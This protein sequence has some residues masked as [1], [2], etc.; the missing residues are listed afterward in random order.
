MI[1]LSLPYPPSLWK[2]YNGFGRK[3]H[4]SDEYKGWLGEALVEI[5]RAKQTPI[6]G[7]FSISI[8]VGRPDERQRDLDNIVKPVLDALQN[9]KLVISDHLA[10]SITIAWSSTVEKRRLNVL[11]WPWSAER[12]AIT[13]LP[14][15]GETA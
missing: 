5:V 9:H 3:R 15:E 4:K 1:V 2:L 6:A 14:P 11:V 7:K 10:E 8:L 13:A 12:A